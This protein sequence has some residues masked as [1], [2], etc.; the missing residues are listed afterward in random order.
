MKYSNCTKAYSSGYVEFF[1]TMAEGSILADL[2]VK[3][4]N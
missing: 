4:R 2:D 3:Y 1:K